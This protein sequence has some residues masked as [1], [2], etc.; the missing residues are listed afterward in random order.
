[1]APYAVHVELSKTGANHS[2]LQ[3]STAIALINCVSKTT[4]RI[5]QQ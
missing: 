2:N 3:N 1:M 5:H 4:E